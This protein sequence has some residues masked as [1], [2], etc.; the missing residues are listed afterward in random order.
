[1]PSRLLIPAPIGAQAIIPLTLLGVRED[2]VSLIDF[3]EPLLCLWIIRI[4][5]WMVLASE[6][7]EG[8]PD[9]FLAGVSVYA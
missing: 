6:S 5:V 8:A 4:D 9:I 1:M 3:L 2:F 7:P